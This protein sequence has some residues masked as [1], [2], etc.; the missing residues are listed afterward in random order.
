MADTITDGRTPINSADAVGTVWVDL[1]DSAATLDNE[2]FIEGSASIGNYC[3]D[4]RDATYYK[5]ATAQNLSNNHI[6]AWMNCGIVGLLATKANQ[7]F[8]FRATGDT[9]TNYLEW[10][11]GGSNSWPTTIKGGWAMVVVDL[12]STPSRTGGTPPATSSIR[13]LGFT[14]VTASVMPRMAD[15]VWVDAMWRLP[16]GS[17]GII[18]QGRNGGS[19]DWTWADIVSA[20]DTGAWGTCKAGPGGSVTLNTPVRFGANDATTHQFSDTNQIILWENQ[21]YAASDL[22]KLTV[23]GGSGTQLYRAG[24]RQGSGD[25]STGNQGWV[26]AA[27]STG[28]RWD[29]D[30]DDANI[31]VC[32]LLG[33][34]IIHGKDFQIDQ[35]NTEIR[36]TLLNDVDSMSD[37]TG[38]FAK[39]TIVDANTA[40]GTALIVSTNLDEIKNN[41]FTF[42]DGHAIEVAP[43]GAGPFTFTLTGNSFTGYGADDTNDAALYI[44]PG[45]SSANITINVT[46]AALPTRR[47]AAGYSGTL[48]INNNVNTTITVKDGSSNAIVGARVSI[49]LV[50]D[51]SELLAGT[52]DGDGE[53][54]G[55]IPSGSGAV[56]V[57]ARKGSGG[58][59]DYIPV[60]SLQTVGTTDFNVTVTMNEDVNNAT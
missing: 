51:N 6:Y 57:R 56:S 54:T 26:I 48:T 40:D 35:A 5:Y 15:N 16:D 10:D 42:S 3:T 29:F 33:C 23:I 36:S 39:N 49:R 24:V 34:T 37:S 18:V 47:I 50:S 17:D 13:R 43:T 2:I 44:N 12:E 11:I 46:D 22:Y 38:K 60:A 45:T 59:T 30:A 53:V 1:S 14:Y 4:S 31:D 7:G 20:A 21:E 52:T 28:V 19:T 41:A 32:E 27:E 9:I 55:S 58:G 8:T 25:T